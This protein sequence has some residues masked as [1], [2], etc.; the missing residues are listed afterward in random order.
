MGE[1]PQHLWS[2]N[3]LNTATTHTC[4]SGKPHWFPGSACV[5]KLHHESIFY[6]H[7]RRETFSSQSAKLEF[8]DRSQKT[9]KHCF[10]YYYYLFHKWN[11]LLW[12]Q[13]GDFFHG[14]PLLR[15]EKTDL[16]VIIQLSFL[17]RL[18]L[19]LQLY[20]FQLSTGRRFRLVIWNSTSM[21]SK[22]KA[23]VNSK[24]HDQRKL[25]SQKVCHGKVKGGYGWEE[26]GKKGDYLLS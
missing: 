19:R 22:L 5:Q 23:P 26:R 14:I 3:P 7:G 11:L 24:Y 6:H 12:I 8:Q 10:F 20:Y 16:L 25:P 4:G 2:P 18:Q 9:Q 15:A 17:E 21:P 1:R 13:P